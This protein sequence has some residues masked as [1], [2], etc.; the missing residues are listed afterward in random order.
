M[1]IQQ[2]HEVCWILAILPKMEWH[3]CRSGPSLAV[4][5]ARRSGRGRATRSPVE[6]RRLQRAIEWVDSHL[7]MSSNCYR[8]ALL[9]IALDSGAASEPLTMGFRAGGGEGSGHAWVGTAQSRGTYD[10]VISV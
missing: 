3:R 5:S 7:P 10:A 2:I 4:A 8:R 1:S 6:R 9:E